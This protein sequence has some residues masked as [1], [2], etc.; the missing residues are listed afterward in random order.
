MGTVTWRPTKACR[1]AAAAIQAGDQKGRQVFTK[2]QQPNIR[3]Q[4]TFNNMSLHAFVV[5]QV[6]KAETR[7]KALILLL[8]LHHPP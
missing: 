3:R 7:V 8:L 4:D 2:P 6:N 5:V 1:T